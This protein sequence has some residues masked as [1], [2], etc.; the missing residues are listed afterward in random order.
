M[1]RAVEI[2]PYERDLRNEIKKIKSDPYNSEHLMRYYNSRIAEG[3]S[4]GRILKCMCTIRRISQMLGKSFS[5]ATKDDFV[6]IVA[7]IEQSN[8]A[9]WTKRDCKVVLKHFYKWFRNWEDG[10]PPEVRWIKKTR[11]AENKKPI[12]PQDLLTPEEKMALIRATQNPRDRAL[13]EVCAESG[14]RVGEILTLHIKDVQFDSI[15]AKLFINGKVGEDFAR[16]IAS[17]PTLSCWLNQHPLRDNPDAPVWVG[18]GR[19]NKHKQITYPV[20]KEILKRL[21]KRAGIKKRIFFYIF[22][23]TRVDETQGILTE[24]QQCMMFGWKFGSQMPAIYMKR[25]GKHIDNAQSI[26]NGIKSIQKT[27]TNLQKPSICARCNSQNSYSSKFCDKCGML[28][29]VSAVAEIDHKK[30]MLDRLLYGIV[31]E[32]EKF[33]ELRGAL[34]RI[35]KDSKDAEVNR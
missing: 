7:E 32:P 35:C 21:A 25:Y 11:S 6:R 30:M 1:S 8:L 34:V 10:S 5:D 15:G 17:A 27:E 18:L 19:S 13:I 23:H 26:M 20:A 28:L 14:R 9:D 29:D 4:K 2:Y 22:R 3:I 33:E 12:L 31:S 16:I 24:P